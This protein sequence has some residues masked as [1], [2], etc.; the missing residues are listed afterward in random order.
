MRASYM[1]PSSMI[2]TDLLEASRV[3]RIADSI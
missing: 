2:D 1:G 3:V